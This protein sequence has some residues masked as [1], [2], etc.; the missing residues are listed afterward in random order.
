MSVSKHS[1]IFQSRLGLNRDGFEKKR[2]CDFFRRPESLSGVKDIG[3]CDMVSNHTIC[4]GNINFCEEPEDLKGYL[5]RKIEA[6]K[7][8]Q[9]F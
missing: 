2:G 3:Y 8:G 5:I 4:E 1:L 7:L 9:L 6:E